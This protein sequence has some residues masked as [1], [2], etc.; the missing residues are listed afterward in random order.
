MMSNFLQRKAAKMKNWKIISLTIVLL[1]LPTTIGLTVFYLLTNPNAEHLREQIIRFYSAGL[2]NGDGTFSLLSWTFLVLIAQAISGYGF[3]KIRNDIKKTKKVHGKVYKAI[4]TVLVYIF[5]RVMLL[6]FALYELLVFYLLTLVIFGE[7]LIDINDNENLTTS[8]LKSIIETIIYVLIISGSLKLII[9]WWS[10]KA[11]SKSF[12]NNFLIKE[13]T[14]EGRIV[15]GLQMQFCNIAFVLILPL[16]LI[17]VLGWDVQDAEKSL[18]FGL[19]SLVIACYGF[20]II[21]S[22][23][24]SFFFNPLLEGPEKL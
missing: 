16:T 21:K 3:N 1:F 2:S 6:T 22:N 17:S 11:R 15:F 13:E 12:I 8:I 18:F 9:N 5:Y 23:L 14:V 24:F 20:M 4:L 19:T 7:I 10:K